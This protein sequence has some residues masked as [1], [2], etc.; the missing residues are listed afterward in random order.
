MMIN[1]ARAACVVALYFCVRSDRVV[2]RLGRAPLSLRASKPK[3]FPFLFMSGSS[4]NPS[5]DRR[6]YGK[7]I[8]GL[9]SPVS[10]K[11]VYHKYRSF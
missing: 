7:E 10:L 2:M 6:K 4:P 5:A 9:R 3:K 11:T 1:F 8:F